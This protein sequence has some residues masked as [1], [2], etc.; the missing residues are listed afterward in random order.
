MLTVYKEIDH[1]VSETLGLFPNLFNLLLYFFYPH[2]LTVAVSRDSA[3]SKILDLSW[4]TLYVCVCMSANVC[5]RVRSQSFLYLAWYMILSGLGH[6][7][8]F[9]FA[10]HL[11]DIAMGFKTLRTILSSVTHNGKQVGRVCVCLWVCVCFGTIFIFD[12]KFYSCLITGY[13]ILLF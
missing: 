9:F 1:S 12:G 11:L 7:N 5:M 13:S 3:L 4:S 2:S 8:N 6:Y 10:A